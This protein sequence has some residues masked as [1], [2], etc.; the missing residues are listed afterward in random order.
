MW[1]LLKK[2]KKQNKK[3]RLSQRIFIIQVKFP[4]QNL[5]KNQKKNK[6]NRQKRNLKELK[7]LKIFKMDMNLMPIKFLNPKT[8][9]K[10]KM[11]MM[12]L[13][14]P[15]FSIPSQNQTIMAI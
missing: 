9:N 5:R 14:P 11:L 15:K 10:I 8:Y 6:K 1:N 12:L 2:N 7:K 4:N 13:K 3:S